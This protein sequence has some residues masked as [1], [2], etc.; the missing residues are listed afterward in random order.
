VHVDA[1]LHC[2][3][4]KLDLIQPLRGVR[5]RQIDAQIHEHNTQPPKFRTPSLL[6][7]VDVGKQCLWDVGI[8]AFPDILKVRCRQV[9][10]ELQSPSCLHLHLR[11]LLVKR[12]EEMVLSLDLVCLEEIADHVKHLF[13]DDRLPTRACA[14]L[15]VER[16][17]QWVACCNVFRSPKYSSHMDNVDVPEPEPD[18]HAQLDILEYVCIVQS[19][20]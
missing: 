10:L 15:R 17:S 4:H 12:D 3:N 7:D 2:L 8:D 14:M 5:I 18:L 20:L 9:V 16:L 13:R 11:V 19:F 1:L 6:I